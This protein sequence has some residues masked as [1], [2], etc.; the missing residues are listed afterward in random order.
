MVREKANISIFFYFG[1]HT[2]WKCMLCYGMLLSE[3]EES[4]EKLGGQRKRTEPNCREQS[5]RT[6]WNMKI[7]KAGGESIT[8]PPSAGIRLHGAYK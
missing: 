1:P 4:L 5:Q 2:V 8:C 6:E 3:L 7:N